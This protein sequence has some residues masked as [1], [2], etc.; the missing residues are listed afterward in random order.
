MKNTGLLSSEAN[1]EII[2]LYQAQTQQNVQH[3]HMET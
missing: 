3:F 1:V 2:K